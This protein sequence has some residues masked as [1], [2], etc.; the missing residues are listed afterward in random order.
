MATTNKTLGIGSTIDFKIPLVD[1]NTQ[2]PIPISSIYN[3]LVDLFT[4]EDRP[5]FE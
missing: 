3:V 2:L 5:I 1:S 4:F